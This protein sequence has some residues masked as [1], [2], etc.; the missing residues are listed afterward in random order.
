[1]LLQVMEDEFEV[2]VD[3]GSEI[4]VATKIM[5]IRTEV[6]DGNSGT[7]DDMYA[8]WQEKK[9]KPAP[10]VKVQSQSDG[11]ESVDDEDWEDDGDTEMAD[12]PP[13]TPSTPKSKHPPEVDEDGFTKVV[14]K[15]KR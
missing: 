9:D 2:V 6:R 15:K 10:M 14:G 12:A 7:V 4:P 11:E 3:D 13:L 8:K 5:Q 1:M